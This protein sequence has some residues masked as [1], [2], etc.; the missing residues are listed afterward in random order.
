MVAAGA[1]SFRVTAFFIPGIVGD[2][3]SVE[4]AYAE[5]RRLIE[6]ELGHP[7]SARRISRL[8]TRRGTLD[9]ITEVGSRDPLRGGIVVAIFDMGPNRPFI[10]CRQDELGSR[11]GTREILGT[12]AY[13]V[14]E[15]DA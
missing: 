10:I 1:S 6:V 11:D 4:D 14:L 13:S 8:W 12:H 5:M 9:C 7:P 3:Y 2:A 15:F